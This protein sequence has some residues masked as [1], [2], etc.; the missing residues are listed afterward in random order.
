MSD[1]GLIEADEIVLATGNATPRLLQTVSVPL[2][3]QSS[4]GYWY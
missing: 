2:D 4:D 1:V 3:M